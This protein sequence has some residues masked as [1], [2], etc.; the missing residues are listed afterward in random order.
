MTD[1]DK[2]RADWIKNK[3]TLKDLATKH[4]V[5]LSAV[6]SRKTR[7]GWGVATDSPKVATK[8]TKLQP[9]DTKVATKRKNGTKKSTIDGSD[10]IKKRRGGNPNPKN[11]FTKRNKAA[12]KH[13]FYSKYLPAET[14]Q[15]FNEIEDMNH[16]EMLWTVIKMKFAAI[17]KAQEIMYVADSEDHSSMVKKEMRIDIVNETETTTKE[18]WI[19]EHENFTAQT[20][21]SEFIKAQARAMAELRSLIKQYHAMPDELAINKKRLELMDATL[22]KTMAETSKLKGEDNEIYE[23]DGFLEALDGK[24]E[25]VWADE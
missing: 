6:K 5:S 13:G 19:I 7:E 4:N 23:D 17:I 1:W 22:Q 21:Q 25:E 12:V 24:V 15:I 11:Q 3:P 20:K 16:A 14:L 18:T 10:K 2:I 9:K 8:T